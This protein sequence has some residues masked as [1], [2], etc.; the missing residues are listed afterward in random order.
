MSFQRIQKYI[1]MENLPVGENGR[2]CCRACG[3]EVPKGR[4]TLCSRS[5]VEAH[6]VKTSPSFTRRLLLKR[7]KG[8]CAGCRLDTLS[9]V[10]A[11]QTLEHLE[12]M[13][14]DRQASGRK[15]FPRSMSESIRQ[16]KVALGLMWTGRRSLWDADH[17]VSVVEGGGECSIE[18]YQ[19]LCVWCHREKTA[20]LAADLAEKRLEKA[21][22]K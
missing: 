22:G 5:C 9:V 11:I 12:R 1:P 7:D 21:E 18:N 20:K 15:H 13:N 14:V 19:T 4:R 8:V 10:G 2:R 3:K 6:L 17:I 16:I